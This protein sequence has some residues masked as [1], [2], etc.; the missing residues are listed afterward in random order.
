MGLMKDF[1]I[2]CY[3]CKKIYLTRRLLVHQTRMYS[4]FKE[5][6]KFYFKGKPTNRIKKQLQAINAFK[7][8]IPFR[9]Q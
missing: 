9:K 1:L 5:L 3:C 7:K 6:H 8:T 2:F 4:W